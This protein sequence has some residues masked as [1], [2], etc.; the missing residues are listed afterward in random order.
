ML[1][2]F[3][4]GWIDW[5]VVQLY[6][7]HLRGV[8]TRRMISF[9]WRVVSGEIDRLAEFFAMRDLTKFFGNVSDLHRRVTSIDGERKIGMGVDEALSIATNSI[10]MLKEKQFGE[11][12]FGRL[13][14]KRCSS[15]AV[16]ANP[17]LI[18]AWRRVLLKVRCEESRRMS[19][20]RRFLATALISASTSRSRINKHTKFN[21]SDGQ[22]LEEKRAEFTRRDHNWHSKANG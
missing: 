11:N 6:S 5:F 16:S 19:H 2:F 13:T 7:T 8:V 15:S 21:A 10:V 14:W 4:T 1:F 12:L 18:K 17:L 20:L 9:Q 3:Q 22:W